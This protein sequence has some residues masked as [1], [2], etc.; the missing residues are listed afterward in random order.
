L[1][2]KAEKAKRS[3][4]SRDIL[5]CYGVDVFK[6]MSRK[7]NR[8]AKKKCGA[9]TPQCFLG[10]GC[11]YVKDCCRFSDSLNKATSEAQLSLQCPLQK[12]YIPS[13]QWR[14]SKKSLGENVFLHWMHGSFIMATPPSHFIEYWLV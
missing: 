7:C 9:D 1:L 14:T 12:K 13:S 5:L 11:V 8:Y 6:V 3:C 2:R 10:N 4:A